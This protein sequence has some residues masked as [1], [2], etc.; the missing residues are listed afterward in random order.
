M[1]KTLVSL[2]LVSLFLQCNSQKIFSLFSNR[3]TSAG[4]EFNPPFSKKIIKTKDGGFAVL[5]NNSPGSFDV[6]GN[7]TAVHITKFNKL[8]TIEWFKL[9]NDSFGILGNDFVQTI[10]SGYAIVGSKREMTGGGYSG[11]VLKTNSS[12]DVLWS[13]IKNSVYQTSTFKL[14]KEVLDGTLLITGCKSPH[15]NKPSVNDS[16]LIVKI[17]SKGDFIWGKLFIDNISDIEVKSTN[18]YYFTGPV[19][20]LTK[21]DSNGNILF[22]MNLEYT[23]PK[24]Q[25]VL[26]KGKFGLGHQIEKISNGLILH[27]LTKSDVKGNVLTKIGFDG[28]V[29]WSVCHSTSNNSFYNWIKIFTQNNNTYCISSNSISRYNSDG[30]LTLFKYC[31][32]YDYVEFKDIFISDNSDMYFT[33]TKLLSNFVMKTDSNFSLNCG[34]AGYSYPYNDSSSYY[35]RNE[36]DTFYQKLIVLTENNWLNFNISAR[37]LTPISLNLLPDRNISIV[38]DTIF[39]N[40]EINFYNDP[41][42]YRWVECSNKRITIY[43]PNSFSFPKNIF[44]P[45]DNKK[46]ALVVTHNRCV[47][48]SDCFSINKSSN[49]TINNPTSFNIYPNPTKDKFILT[50]DYQIKSIEITDKTGR[51]IMRINESCNN[52]DVSHLPKGAY[53]INVKTDK[54]DFIEKIIK[55]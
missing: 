2:F 54:G 51:Q 29:K 12:G 26:T 21:L 13:K 39:A 50:S 32:P 49:S 41:D 47:D 4:I 3:E 15:N 19:S 42:G 8:G 5:S 45:K 33:G 31:V 30:F 48:T 52:I 27:V 23:I 17:S 18:E 10:D 36:V 46:Y 11:L 35:L 7:K 20:D 24:L 38:G 9:Y 6:P 14:I 44:I 25:S 43:E 37:N 16:G 28:S 1:K 22:S 53:F 40:E 34:E 55:E